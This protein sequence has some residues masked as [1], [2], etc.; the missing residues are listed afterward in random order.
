MGNVT[1]FRFRSG[2]L[3][4][5]LL[6]LALCLL[7]GVALA[8]PAGTVGA[9]AVTDLPPE[10]QQTLRLI[11]AGGPFPYSKDGIVFGNYEG[12]LPQR[13]RGYYREYTVTTPRA[14]N[15]GAR[16]II[17][18]GSPADAAEYYYTG[19]HYVTFVRIQE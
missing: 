10:A 14:R 15:R 17:V 13:K 11:K 2:W 12:I 16:R 6:V 1:F 3:Q 7:Q 9:V 8:R 18:G 4:Q 19:N 5:V